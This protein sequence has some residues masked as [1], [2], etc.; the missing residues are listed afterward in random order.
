MSSHG[1]NYEARPSP[2]HHSDV[3]LKT[4]AKC[5]H[6][7]SHDSKRGTECVCS[8]IFIP[9]FIL[10]RKAE[11]KEEVIGYKVTFSVMGLN[12]DTR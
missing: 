7:G 5:H 10:S 9:W 4:P 11:D 3:T 6:A 1:H 12:P 8:L 2:C